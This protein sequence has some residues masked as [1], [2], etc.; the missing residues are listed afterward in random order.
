MRTQTLRSTGAVLLI[1]LCFGCASAPSYD[2]TNFRQH[3]PR[4]ILVLP[5]INQSTDVRGTYG[6]LTTVTK[7]LAEMGYYVFPVALVDQ[8][9]KENGLPGPGEMHQAPLS[10]FAEIFGADAVLYITLAAYGSKYHV[11]NSGAV[12]Q[13][14]GRL[15]DAKTG[16]LLWEGGVLARQR[17][18]AAGGGG[19]IGALVGAAVNQVVAST[20]DMAHTI[21]MD[22][23]QML[24]TGAALPDTQ[25]HADG[26]GGPALLYGP[27]H[28]KDQTQ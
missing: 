6:Y 21:S 13:A 4:S 3:P 11:F 1:S 12:V 24:F 25:A 8:F 7:P 15:V 27:Y 20:S 5:P 16:L 18:G 28:P 19:L 22:A 26:N 17:S 14:R 23:N 9:L 2:Y 10:K